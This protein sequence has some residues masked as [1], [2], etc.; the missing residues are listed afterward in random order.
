MPRIPVRIVLVAILLALALFGGSQPA[1]A[2]PPE[3]PSA[4]AIRLRVATFT[5][6]LGETPPLPPN[7]LADVAE[8]DPDRARLL[9]QFKGPIL[10][11]WREALEASGVVILD[12]I[13]DYAYRIERHGV[14]LEALRALPG[15]VWVGAYE[16]GYRLSPELQ[17]TGRQLVRVDLDGSPPEDLVE[18]LA[19]LGAE[20]VGQSGNVLAVEI[21]T[22]QLPALAALEGVAWVSP[23]SPPSAFNDV[24]AGELRAAS[25]WSSSLHGEGQTIAIA[26]TGLDTGVDLPQVYG[27]MH[28]DLDNRVDHIA[29][30]RADPIYYADLDNPTADDGAAD[31]GEGH[32]THVAGSAVG[33]GARS[34]G[35]IRG[36]AY[37]ARLVFQAVEQYCDWKPATFRPDG[38]YLVGVPADLMQLYS[39]AY[40][41]GARI[42]SNSWGWPDQEGV[43]TADSRATDQFVWEH[44]DMVVLFAAG[45]E[46][47]DANSDGRVDSGS[48]TAPATAKN[49]IVVG[50][51]ENRRYDR[52]DTYGSKWSW[53]FPVDPLR[54]DPMANAG[55][56]GMAAFSGRGPTQDGR[57]TPH[58]VAPGTWVV[59]TRSSQASGVGWGIASNPFYMYY[60]GSSMSTPQVAGA[61]ALIRQA[62]LL[63]RHTPSAALLK[64]TLIHTARD[65]SGQYASPYGDA[66]AIPNTSEGWG[67]VDVGAAVAAGRRYVDETSV[68]STGQ[69]AVFR[70]KASAAAQPAKFTLVWSDAPAA[71]SA[72]AQ[73]VNDLDLQV[74]TPSGVTYRGN[75]FANSWS[76]AGGSYD[77]TNNVECVYLPASEGGIYTVT[78]RGYNVPIASQSFALVA[79]MAPG[80]MTEQ[81][82]L[83]MILRNAV[84]GSPFADDFSAVNGVWPVITTPEYE[85]SYLE[86]EYRIRAITNTTAL[87]LANRVF[88]HDV[89]AEVSGRAANEG[90]QAYGIVFGQGQDAA[91]D[92]FHAFVVS[93]SG[94][95]AVFRYAFGGWSTVVGWTGSP[96]ILTGEGVNRL[97]VQRVGQLAELRIN[98]ALVETMLGSEIALGEGLGLLGMCWDGATGFSDARFDDL[99]VAGLSSG[100][101]LESVE[102]FSEGALLP[103][104]EP[105]PVECG[106][107]CGHTG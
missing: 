30:W 29:S 88:P 33:N 46:G 96:A 9:V 99:M 87:S 60:G 20:L 42:H 6:S 84:Q 62:Y 38:Y 98:G 12:Y 94:S 27:D 105:P 25:A 104:P 10:P 57:I 80:P 22:A 17:A 34:A 61:V 53:L 86:G 63:R 48:V 100:V 47:R 5:P 45:N 59:S 107:D 56:D 50:A 83:P 106:Q 3:D 24:A 93:R 79:S 68:L 11:A 95:Y 78:I 67:A 70:Y 91:G 97:A 101:A 65:I 102:A 8:E 49:A 4:P 51:S 76:V 54:N 72:A 81:A 41:W 39:Q 43:Y 15:V 85:L 16:P 52:T 2:R 66:P 64:A 69:E 75:V 73:L 28:L 23:L 55:I 31:R 71:L 82:R 36:L 32:G 21:D 89:L 74:T 35:V 18:R 40:A 92:T 77:R 44:R 1:T 19:A 13:P 26:D 37:S 58:V 7:L 90:T 14:A 103:A